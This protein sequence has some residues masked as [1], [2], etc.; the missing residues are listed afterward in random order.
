MDKETANE[1]KELILQEM[2]YREEFRAAR[3]ELEDLV[4]P[5][6]EHVRNC[7]KFWD[8]HLP[9][10]AEVVV[11][12]DNGVSLKIVK[13]KP[14]VCKVESYLPFGIDYTDSKVIEI[15]A[16]LESV[17]KDEEGFDCFGGN[18]AKGIKPCTQWCGDDMCK[19]SNS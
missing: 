4:D 13:P 8:Q 14:E 16:D 12:L 10:I 18:Y 7:N 19:K 3:Q 2:A 1:L 17:L 11:I 9:D 15:E 6:T 5:I